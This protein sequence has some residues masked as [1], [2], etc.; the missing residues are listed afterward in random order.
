MANTTTIIQCKCEL[1]RADAVASRAYRTSNIS[2]PLLQETLWAV[3]KNPTVFRIRGGRR[4][5]GTDMG[6]NPWNFYMYVRFTVRT[7]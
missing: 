4:L 2:N 5:K 6:I 1:A 3:T 7:L